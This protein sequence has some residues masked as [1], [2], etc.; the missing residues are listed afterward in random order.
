MVN[1]Q[2]F[3]KVALILAFILAFMSPPSIFGQMVFASRE[4]RLFLSLFVMFL[5]LGIATLNIYDLIVLLCA[6]F[7]LSVEILRQ[8][9]QSSNILSYY[10]I[11]LFYVFLFITLR[12]NEHNRRM[13]LTLWIQVAYFISISSILL[14]VLHQFTSFNTDFFDFASLGDFSAR[15]LRF[16]FL[17]ATQVKNFGFFTVIRSYSYFGEPQYAAF[18]FT[19]N[20]LLANEINNKNSKYKKLFFV[21]LLAGLL[22][23]SVTF[24]VAMVIIYML[25]LVE[26]RSIFE[27]LIIAFFLLLVAIPLFIISED[28][29]FT[30]FGGLNTSYGDREIRMLNAWNI[31]KS[32]SIFDFLFGHGVS[33][34]G[35][36]DRGLSAGFFHVLVERGL[37]GL[38]FVLVMLSVFMRRNILSF[39]IC[40]LY[41]FTL[42]WYVNYIFWMGILALWAGASISK[43]RT[44]NVN[45]VSVIKSNGELLPA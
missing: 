35:D 29:I 36:A 22:T 3:Y 43:S 15:D 31:L 39:L 10:A 30:F 19:I 42:T 24:Y 4:L 38:L 44:L 2:V 28:I 20:V 6:T 41:L 27:S 13:F 8:I 34:I 32:S 33:Y 7:L 37:T 9:S 26:R 21:N 16:S 5:F 45:K 23:F 17:G 18:Y 11:I 40:L 14:F 25:R 1:K 12:N